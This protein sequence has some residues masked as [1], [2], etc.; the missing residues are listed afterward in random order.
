MDLTI[1]I[2]L[3]LIELCVIGL[4][5]RTA[6]YLV[7]FEGT[8]GSKDSELFGRLFAIQQ[9]REQLLEK[10]DNTPKSDFEYKYNKLYYEIIRAYIESE[11]ERKQIYSELELE[12]FE[13]DV[14]PKI[15]KEV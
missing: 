5:A 8:F 7:D 2:F 1:F 12:Y 13:P 11:A 4:I 6:I 14:M 15:M 3:F 9:D 10:W